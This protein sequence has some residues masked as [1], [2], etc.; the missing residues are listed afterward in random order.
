MLLVTESNCAWKLT[1]Y[2]YV[3]FIIVI[4]LC[5]I[6]Q[7]KCVI[8]QYKCVIYQYKGVIYQYK[9]VWFSLKSNYWVIY[10]NYTCSI[11]V[12]LPL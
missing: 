1:V 10:C 5:W 12:V 8:Y 9:C 6:Y 2:V 11:M 7:Y 3:C 4:E